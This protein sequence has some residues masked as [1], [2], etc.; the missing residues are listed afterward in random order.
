MASNRDTKSTYANSIFFDSLSFLKPFHIELSNF[1]TI[2]WLKW[3][4][5]ANRAKV[6]NVSWLSYQNSKKS[7]ELGLKTRTNNDELLQSGA[8]QSL[9]LIEKLFDRFFKASWPLERR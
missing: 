3:G 2:S 6:S 4:A 5:V 8:Y 9:C 7:L 1:L